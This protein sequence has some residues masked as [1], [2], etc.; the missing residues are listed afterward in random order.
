MTNEQSQYLLSLPKKIIENNNLLNTITINQE[1]PFDKRFELISENDDEFT[2]LWEIQQSKKNTIRISLHYQEN[3][4]K[5]GLLRID[6]NGGHI[7]PETISDSV[8]EK[9][10]PYAGKVFLNNEHHVHY[11]V[12][13]YKSLSWAIPLIDDEFEVKELNE[14]TD[15]NNSLANAVQLFAKAINIETEITI[16]TLLL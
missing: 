11:H 4:S 16:N 15:F 3:D 2:F 12:E 9:F 5:T 8:P 7:N 13:G 1:F 10:H 6:Y 14:G